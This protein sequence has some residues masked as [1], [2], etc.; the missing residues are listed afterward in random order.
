MKIAELQ[1]FMSTQCLT[2]QDNVESLLVRLIYEN[3]IENFHSVFSAYIKHMENLKKRN[4]AE[5]CEAASL[6]HIRMIGKKFIGQEE[7]ELHVINK[8]SSLDCSKE[9]E[10]LSYDAEESERLFRKLYN[11]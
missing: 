1:E 7:R 10:R 4:K 5:L 3:K 2:P 11:V 8:H 9:N 6:L